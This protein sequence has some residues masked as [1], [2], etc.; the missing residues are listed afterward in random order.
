[1]TTRLLDSPVNM[2][3]ASDRLRLEP[4]GPK[5]A[6][7]VG[8]TAEQLDVHIQTLYDLV[9]SVTGRGERWSVVPILF[10]AS[11]T[12]PTG[13]TAANYTSRTTASHSQKTRIHS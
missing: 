8:R 7:H 11:A 6:V 10:D 2:V 5:T 13:I 3:L 4:V 1:M 12:L 9:G